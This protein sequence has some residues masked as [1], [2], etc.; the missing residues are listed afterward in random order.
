MHPPEKRGRKAR[1]GIAHAR[2]LLKKYLHWLPG[3]PVATR[4]GE[5]LWEAVPWAG[6][7]KRQSLWVGRDE[8]RG[9]ARALTELGREF[10][11]PLAKLVDDPDGWLARMR[12][13]LDV[14]QRAIHSRSP[15]DADST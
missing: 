9:M 2:V 15:I 3:R 8:L 1:Q 10:R 4:R 7:G 11:K 6:E 5:V 12:H 14:L 13:L